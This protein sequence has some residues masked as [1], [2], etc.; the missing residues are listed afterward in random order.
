MLIGRRLMKRLRVEKR[1]VLTR[2]FIV[3]FIYYMVGVGLSDVPT[4]ICGCT[5][6]T[7]DMSSNVIWM[8]NW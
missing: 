1:G 8:Q 6:S 4:C 3:Q 2:S 5:D 7:L